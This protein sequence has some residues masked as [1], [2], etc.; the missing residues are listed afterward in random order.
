MTHVLPNGFH[1]IR[2]FGILANGCRRKTLDA[3]REALGDTDLGPEAVACDTDDRTQSETGSDDATE[4]LCCPHCGK[5]EAMTPQNPSAVPIA[6][7]PC[8]MSER[9]RPDGKDQDRAGI[10]P[11]RNRWEIPVHDAAVGKRR[12]DRRR[13]PLASRSSPG[14]AFAGI[15]P[16]HHASN[17]A[18]TRFNRRLGHV[19]VPHPG[20]VDL[21]GRRP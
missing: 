21:P 15:R 18:I 5:P 4:P 7:H 14:P 11:G 19:S 13:L 3:A 20:N 17:Q 9:S 6:A 8:D 10:R 1:R 12:P 16:R 2:Y